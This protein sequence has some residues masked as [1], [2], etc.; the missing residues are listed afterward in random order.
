MPLLKSTNK[1]E[2]PKAEEVAQTILGARNIVQSTKGANNEIPDRTVDPISEKEN[3]NDQD[4]PT[5]VGVIAALGAKRQSPA[6]APA[7]RPQL[8]ARE[9]TPSSETARKP[10]VKPS[11][12]VTTIQEERAAAVIPPE[13]PSCTT[14][15]MTE[16][17]FRG[18]SAGEN[19]EQKMASKMH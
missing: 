16:E 11:R 3:E 6:G 4:G 8:G 5:A 7:S 15:A 13:K 12:V 17:Q 1:S 9:P 10:E 2:L 14:P 18:F 19:L